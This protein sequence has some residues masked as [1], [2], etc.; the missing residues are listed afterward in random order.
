MSGFIDKISGTRAFPYR[1]GD[2]NVWIKHASDKRRPVSSFLQ[3][4]FAQAVGRD[5]FRCSQIRNGIEALNHESIRLR[6]M[7]R[8]GFLVPQI[9]DQTKT[10]LILSDLGKNLKKVLTVIQDAPLRKTLLSKAAQTLGHI[11]S[12]GQY[13]GRPYLQDLT[14][15]NGDIGF[16]DFEHAPLQVMSLREAQALDIWRF[17]RGTARY[18]ENDPSLLP[19]LLKSYRATAPKESIET[20]AE[21]IAILENPNSLSVRLC[22]KFL[23]SIQPAR[24]N[25]LNHNLSLA[26]H[27]AQNL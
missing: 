4:S 27:P 24:A 10:T 17:L 1:W 13:H 18:H 7:H 3:D 25:A 11:H 5:I 12:C 20:L 22:I 14:L 15:C 21:S 9:F 19:D 16:L 23:R 26:L 2:K 8:Q 6:E